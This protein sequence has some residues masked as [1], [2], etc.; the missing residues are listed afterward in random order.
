[1]RI[2]TDKD[3]IGESVRMMRSQLGLS[4]RAF[5]GGIGVKQPIGSKYE[6]GLRIP[7]PIKS[8]IFIRYVAGIRADTGTREG[9]QQLIKLAA[10]Q[11]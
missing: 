10:L 11:P 4:Q 1:M 3:I 7:D 9:A 2:S 8:L 6:A 5:W